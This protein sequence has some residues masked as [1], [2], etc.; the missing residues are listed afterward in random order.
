MKINSYIRSLTVL[1]L[2]LLFLN[3]CIKDAGVEDF[4]FIGISLTADVSAED[5]TKAP[6]ALAP[7]NYADYTIMLYGED[8]GL[9]WQTSFDAFAA[10]VDNVY[11][12][13]PAGTYT[14]YVENCTAAE[15]EEGVGRLR[16]A[17]SK[18]FIVRAGRET[19][20]EVAC[21]VVNAKI[22][23]A[24]D[25]ETVTPDAE[26]QNKTRILCPAGLSVS[27][28]AGRKLSLTL[29]A[30]H[31]DGNAVYY[32]VGE[33][34]TVAL[35]YTLVAGVYPDYEKVIMRYDVP[36]TAA[37]GKWNK[38]TMTASTVTGQ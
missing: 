19:K 30:S 6:V 7:E 20:E 34:G 10:D 25:D 11:R 9:L 33:D 24:Y 18:T 12:R 32:N 21:S 2:M 8:G 13:V 15:A 5:A 28:D 1:Q 35:T 3:S 31:E 37:K 29:S 17:G 27:D 14:V 38:V 26:N 36:F 22:T 4:G 23:I 16:I